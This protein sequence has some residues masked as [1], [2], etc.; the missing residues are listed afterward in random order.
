MRSRVGCEAS[1]AA[2]NSS[3]ARSLC[4]GIPRP[5]SLTG[6]A[7]RLGL[8]SLGH[9]LGLLAT[10]VIISSLIRVSA[11]SQRSSSPIRSSCL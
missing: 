6:R 2:R 11:S 10:R 8:G 7:I 4:K 5:P 1:L 9:S 3:W